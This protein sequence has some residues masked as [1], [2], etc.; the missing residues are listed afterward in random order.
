MS[1]MSCMHAKSCLTLLWPRGLYSTSVFCSWNFPANS[2]WV[3]CHFLLWRI[4]R[5]RGSNLHLL[6]LLHW[7]LVGSLPLRQP[8]SLS[9]SYVYEV[10]HIVLLML[11]PFTFFSSLAFSFSTMISINCY[12]VLDLLLFVLLCVIPN[13]SYKWKGG[14]SGGLDSKVSSSN[15]RDQGLIPGLRRS[16]GERKW[17]PIPVSLPG[18][19]HGQRRLA[20]CSPRSHKESDTTGQLTLLLSYWISVISEKI[21][22]TSQK[23][24]DLFYCKKYATFHFLRSHAYQP[25]CSFIHPTNIY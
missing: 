13:I 21:P 23:N 25:I 4:Y 15:P 7:H 3:D 17:Q 16:P 18:E 5:T 8:G 24:R 6:C 1:S 14:L 10:S 11:F 2:T 9:M 19:S 12:Y 20:S 22:R